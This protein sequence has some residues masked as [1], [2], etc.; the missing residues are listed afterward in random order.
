M[1]KKYKGI[2]FY[3]SSGSGKTYISKII[4]KKTKKSIIIDGDI[5]RKLVSTDLNYSK[6]HREIQIKRVLGIS[7]IAIKSNIFPIIS[8]VYLNK[9]INNICTKDKIL[10]VRIIRKDFQKI[11]RKH[12]TYKNKSDVVGKD[13]FY[14]K[15]FKTSELFN[16]G[17]KSF[18][19]NLKFF[20]ELLII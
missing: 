6:K 2:W 5:V 9:E 20:Q 13:I 1:K 16:N 8:T 4:K 7:K 11:K 12:K 14:E 19:E 3:G 15:N 17:D 10:T 18:S